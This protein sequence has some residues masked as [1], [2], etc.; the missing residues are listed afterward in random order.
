MKKIFNKTL[1]LLSR[2]SSLS[3]TEMS[4]QALNTFLKNH[5]FQTAEFKTL[6]ENLLK[7]LQSNST[8]SFDQLVDDNVSKNFKIIEEM[9]L[10]Q[11]ES[12]RQLAKK[13]YLDIS[14]YEWNWNYSLEQRIERQ[15]I[16]LALMESFEIAYQKRINL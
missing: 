15:Q 12:C 10:F 14:D 7:D 16:A 13:I 11:E 9:L 8:S 1:S 5:N 6:V 4:I 3:N 2:V